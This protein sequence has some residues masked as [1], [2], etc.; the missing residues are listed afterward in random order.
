MNFLDPKTQSLIAFFI[1]VI[2]GMIT[3]YSSIIFSRLSQRRGNKTY[4]T[5]AIASRYVKKDDFLLSLIA[6]YD[7]EVKKLLDPPPDEIIIAV[8]SDLPEE[9]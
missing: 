7:K 8:M 6:T 1:S 9:W 2:A 3:V 4:K 5:N